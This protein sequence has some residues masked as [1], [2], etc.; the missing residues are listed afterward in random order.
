M[1][2]PRDP[3]LFSLYDFV[4]VYGLEKRRE[5]NGTRALIQGWDGAK[6]KYRVV[7]TLSGSQY[8]LDPARLRPSAEPSA[9]VSAASLERLAK[10]RVVKGDVDF[11]AC[12]GCNK[13]HLGLLAPLCLSCGE[14][15]CGECHGDECRYCS[16][17]TRH[18]YKEAVEKLEKFCERGD[19]RAFL[20][21][22]TAH[23]T[24]SKRS[25]S[26][27]L[28]AS[29]RILALVHR[30]FAEPMVLLSAVCLENGLSAEGVRWLER[31]ARCESA[32]AVFRLGTMHDD[33]KHVLEPS[34]A[35]ALAFFERAVK[36]DKNHAGA[37]LGLGRARDSLEDCL[38]AA[39]RGHEEAMGEVANAY[40]R[41]IKGAKKNFQLGVDWLCTAAYLGN[42]NAL[43]CMMK[44][45]VVTRY[46]PRQ[47][48]EDTP[49]LKRLLDKRQAY[50]AKNGLKKNHTPT[51]VPKSAAVYSKQAADD[52]EKAQK[53]HSECEIQARSVDRWQPPFVQEP[54]APS[55]KDL[56]PNK[57]PP[58]P[59]KRASGSTAS[60]FPG[61][62]PKMHFFR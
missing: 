38:E 22:A 52:Y 54:K 5:M 6:G 43:R 2:T 16:A 45:E 1:E 44:F 12:G 53:R 30:G 41:G 24:R 35:S 18:P 42:E 21:L 39:R 34:K 13:A 62:T 51:A 25:G 32:E 56:D 11:G 47:V 20:A 59:K 49:F 40:M 3:G 31:A 4:Q 37:W 58:E 7:A 33:G 26:K 61:P 57:P 9:V 50:L 36:L 55:F 23:L 48:W 19:P 10:I 29:R 14:S 15:V 17:K 60:S 8:L 46:P 28:E 27:L